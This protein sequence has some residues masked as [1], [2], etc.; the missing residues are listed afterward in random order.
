MMSEELG[1]GEPGIVQGE[2]RQ[3]LGY[4]PKYGGEFSKVSV[5]KQHKSG[6]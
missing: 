3:G 5:G 2:N 6:K 1:R 4:C